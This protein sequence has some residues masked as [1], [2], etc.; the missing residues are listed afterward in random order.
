MNRG[1]YIGLGII[2]G[3]VCFMV[4]I[5]ICSWVVCVWYKGV[6]YGVSRG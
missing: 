3:S 1:L 6:I 5:V 4:R 2:V